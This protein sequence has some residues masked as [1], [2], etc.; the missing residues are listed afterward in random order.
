MYI[1]R[2]LHQ[3]QTQQGENPGSIQQLL[4]Q[5]VSRMA[6]SGF[7]L[8]ENQ[9]RFKYIRSLLKP[10]LKIELDESNWTTID[11]Y[12]IVHNEESEINDIYEEVYKIRNEHLLSTIDKKLKEFDRV[13]VIMGSQH[14]IDEQ[15]RIKKIFSKANN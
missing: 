6:E 2:Q 3:Y 13:F 8:K 1:L 14:V 4:E 12:S 5:F 11:A 10:H 15:D 9:T 7:P